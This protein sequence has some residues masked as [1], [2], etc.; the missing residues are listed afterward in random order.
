MLH[1]REA[2][3]GGVLLL[4]ESIVTSSNSGNS[5]SRPHCDAAD[6]QQVRLKERGGEKKHHVVWSHDLHLLTW[7]ERR[8]PP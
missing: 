8:I 7:L 2:H 1:P 3:G 4:P 5:S 6:K